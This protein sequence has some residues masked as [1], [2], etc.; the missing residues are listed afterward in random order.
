[1]NILHNGRPTEASMGNGGSPRWV[2]LAF[3]DFMFEGKTPLRSNTLQLR[4]ILLSLAQ[5]SPLQ[6]V[7]PP[8]TGIRDGSKQEKSGLGLKGLFRREGLLLVGSLLLSGTCQSRPQHAWTG[9]ELNLPQDCVVH[10]WECP[11]LLLPLT[12]FPTLLRQGEHTPLK[13][14]PQKLVVATVFPAFPSRIR[15]K[16]KQKKWVIK[17]LKIH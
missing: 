12:I 16:T 5:E 13:A 14:T 2:A 10:G 3:C 6:W 1:M 9:L 7:L 15:E 11:C 4:M 8:W 17:L